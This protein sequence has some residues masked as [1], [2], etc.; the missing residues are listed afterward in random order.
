MRRGIMGVMA[1]GVA[2]ATLLWGLLAPAIAAHDADGVALDQIRQVAAAVARAHLRVH[3]CERPRELRHQRVAVRGKVERVAL[4][5]LLSDP[6][7][8]S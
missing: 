1:A 7:E 4:R 6:G 8:S 5:G 3:G 2:T